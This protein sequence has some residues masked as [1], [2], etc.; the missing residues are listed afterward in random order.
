MEEFKI[1]CRLCE[2]YEI[3]DVYKPA[4]NKAKGYYEKMT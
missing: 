4:L 3:I 1:E 2:E